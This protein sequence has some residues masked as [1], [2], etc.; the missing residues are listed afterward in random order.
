MFERKGNP[1]DCKFVSFFCLGWLF[2][3]NYKQFFYDERS[4]FM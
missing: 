1:L 4:T 3:E 2:A